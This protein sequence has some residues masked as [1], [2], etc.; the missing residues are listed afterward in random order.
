MA[1][2]EN[3][4]EEEGKKSSSLVG[5]LVMAGIVV[6]VPII[7]GVVVF[8]LV[9]IPML[10]TP[11]EDDAPPIDV[12]DSDVE[13]TMTFLMPQESVVN[14]GSGDGRINRHMF[15]RRPAFDNPLN[16]LWVDSIKT[17]LFS[18]T[19]QG[20]SRCIPNHT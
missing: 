19:H 16:L 12:I 7:L 18:C 4:A 15:I 20:R 9:L 14:D 8:K 3:A 5:K 13:K 2:E 11:P 17:Q 10:G 1:E 6:L